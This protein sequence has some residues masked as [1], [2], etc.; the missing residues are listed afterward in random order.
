VFGGIFYQT[1]KA[2]SRIL[3]YV[4]IYLG[5]KLLSSS[6]ELLLTDL[7]YEIYFSFVLAPNKD[8]AVS[9]LHCCKPLRQTSEPQPFGLGVTVRTS[10]LTVDGR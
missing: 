3:F 4:I 7:N 6:G 2:V 10:H 1:S 5:W 8:L 9:Y